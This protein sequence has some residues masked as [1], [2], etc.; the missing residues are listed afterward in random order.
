MLIAI[1]KIHIKVISQ[2]F[3]KFELSLKKHS[4]VKNWFQ[5]YLYQNKILKGRVLR[6]AKHRRV[7]TMGISFFI[8]GHTA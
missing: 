8:F 2:L 1:L 4:L 5:Y 7:Y 3:K 6:K